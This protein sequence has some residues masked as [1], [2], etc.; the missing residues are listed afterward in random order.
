MDISIKKPSTALR[1]A[2]VRMRKFAG[3]HVPADP[4]RGYTDRMEALSGSLLVGYKEGRRPSSP[5]R[6]M[7]VAGANRARQIIRKANDQFAGI[8]FL[9]KNESQL[10]QDILA[11]HFKLIAGDDGGGVLDSNVVNQKFRLKK[12]FQTDRRTVVE[13]IRRSML[14]ISF[15]L[16]TG[17]YLIDIDADH[18][19]IESGEVV[20]PGNADHGTLGYVSPEKTSLDPMTWRTASNRWSSGI[21]CGFR[22]GE[23]HIPLGRATEFTDISLAQL[24]IHEAT[25]KYLNTDDEAYATQDH[26]PNLD[27]TQSLNNAD[28]Y[29]WAAVSLYCKAVKAAT[30]ALAAGDDFQCTK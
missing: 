12:I 19:D 21:T 5:N 25:H 22:H 16:N 4:R 23:I 28:S 10:M 18:R 26:Y 29:A 13:K 27:L 3:M 30:P 15:H 1:E 9:R 8:C 6:A 24:I 7:L 17:I 11:T 20:D 14:S 2:E